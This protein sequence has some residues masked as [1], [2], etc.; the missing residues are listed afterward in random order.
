M[1]RRSYHSLFHQRRADHPAS[2]PEDRSPCKP[3]PAVNAPAG[4]CGRTRPRRHSD[5]GELRQQC[6]PISPYRR[7]QQLN[8]AS[9]TDENAIT[10]HKRPQSADPRPLAVDGAHTHFS[11]RHLRPQRCDD[12]LVPGQT[13]QARLEEQ[14]IPGVTLSIGTN[15]QDVRG[16]H[17]ALVCPVASG[18]EEARPP[19]PF[20]R[21]SAPWSS[22]FSSRH[23]H[24]TP[25][26]RI[27]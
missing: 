10:A 23:N 4:A 19:D 21:P 20:P 24:Q 16:F 8:L 27:L 7:L 12:A 11:R 9:S 13:L 17:D 6:Q 22:P 15:Q 5:A 2:T 14:L 26:I 25:P 1:S 18:H 3:P